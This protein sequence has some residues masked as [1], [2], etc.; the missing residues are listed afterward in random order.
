[1]FRSKFYTFNI[2][3]KLFQAV[4]TPVVLYGA[5]SW[6]LTKNMEVDLLR[7]WRRI[8]RAVQCASR[9]PE[10]MWGDYVQRT[11]A[12]VEDKFHSLGYEN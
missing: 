12:V 9:L 1:M 5:A 4:V 11:T 8:L 7:A 3:A 6:T 2:K 10:E